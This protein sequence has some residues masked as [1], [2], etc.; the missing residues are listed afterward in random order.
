MLQPPDSSAH[1]QRSS[2]TPSSYASVRTVSIP[3]EQATIGRSVVIKGE[4]SG[5]EALYIDGRVEGALNLP[6]HRITVGREGSVTADIVAREVVIMGKVK[7]NIQCADRVEVRCEG[8]LDGDIVAQRI[9]IEDGAML[10][11]SVQ[12]RIPETRKQPEPITDLKKSSSAEPA[13]AA[14]ATAGR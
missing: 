6:D 8:S 11:G 9:S 7:G 14:A 5:A 1:P 12:V 2:P 4:V 10:K 13:K 3:A